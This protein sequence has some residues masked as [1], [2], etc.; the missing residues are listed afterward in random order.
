MEGGGR[1]DG[2]KWKANQLNKKV[3]KCKIHCCCHIRVSIIQTAELGGN[4]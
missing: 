2:W 1:N 3:C 4:D